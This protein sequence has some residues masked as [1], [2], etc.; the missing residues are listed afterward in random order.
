MVCLFV[1]EFITQLRI[2]V[3][4]T[5]RHF[6]VFL[7]ALINEKELLKDIFKTYFIAGIY[8]LKYNQIVVK[9][10]PPGEHRRY[11]KVQGCLNCFGFLDLRN[12]HSFLTLLA[13]PY[14]LLSCGFSPII[15]VSLEHAVQIFKIAQHRQDQYGW[16]CNQKEDTYSSRFF[17][18]MMQ[19]HV[20]ILG[21]YM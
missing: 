21:I 6:L 14:K 16:C 17:F 19:A 8:F 11:K 9:K 2:Q 20:H 12:G 5:L 18:L 7:V 1:L 15:S 4:C 3:F 13:K 10:V